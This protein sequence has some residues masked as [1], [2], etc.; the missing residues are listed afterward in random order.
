MFNVAHVIVSHLID[1]YW[2]L[3]CFLHIRSPDSDQLRKR[4]RLAVDPA[5][6]SRNA[7]C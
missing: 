2:P 5:S 3:T 7:F 4:I 1:K 6:R